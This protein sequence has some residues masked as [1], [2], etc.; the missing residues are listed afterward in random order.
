VVEGEHVK[1][2]LFP[3]LAFADRIGWERG[4]GALRAEEIP[5]RAEPE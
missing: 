2:L 3:T 4:S 1:A 5:R